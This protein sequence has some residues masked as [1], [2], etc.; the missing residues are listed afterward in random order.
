MFI[1]SHCHLDRLD[2]KAHDGSIEAAL[3]AARAVG[4]RHFLTVSVNLAELPALRTLAETHPDIS[5][6]VGV[7]PSEQLATEDEPTTE[8][9]CQLADHP[10]VIA[11]G[12]TGLD[13]H[14]HPEAA[15]VQQQRF[16]AHIQA[17]RQTQKPLIVHTRAAKEDTLALLRSEGATAG[18][19]HCFT[20]DWPMAKAA[21]DLGFYISLSGIVSFANAAD[22]RDVAAK[23]PAD[24]LLIETDSP[25]LAP[26]PYRGK[27]NEPR[28]LPAVAE[29]VAKARGVSVEELAMQTSRNFSQLFGV[30]L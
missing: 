6:S 17:S 18:V 23:V 25:Y 5:F 1:D 19:M 12:E 15:T 26:I 11:I 9:L 7:H 28:Y 8:Q 30:S 14:Y 13:Y 27:K 24:R 3:A 29:A 21:L 10:R 20:E 2:L 16:A 22:L 4:V